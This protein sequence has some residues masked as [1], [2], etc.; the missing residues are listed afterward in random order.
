[1]SFNARL[2]ATVA[3]RGLLCVGLDPIYSELP[4]RFQGD[5]VEG[6]LVAANMALIEATAPY[7][8]AFK[9]QM[10][11]Y[12]AEGPAGF[13]AL[14]ATCRYLKARY[15]DHL[16][17]LDA[18]YGDVSHVMARS[19][20]EAFTLCNADAVTAFAHPGRLALAPLLADPERGCFVVCR[21]SN[22]GAPEMQDI[23]TAGGD[24]YYLALARQVAASWNA[25]DNCG[26]VAGATYPAEMAAIRAEAPDL[27]LLVPG[28]GAQGGD[29][30]AAVQAGMDGAG[31]GMLISA[32]RSLAAADPGAMAAGL[33]AQIRAALGAP[34]PAPHPGDPQV[35]ALVVEL[36]DKGYIQWKTVQLKSGRMSPYYLNLRGVSADPP[37]FGRLCRAFA[38]RA[39]ALGWT[40][41]VLLGIAHAGIP[42][43]VGTGG[44]LGRPAG[45]VRTDAKGYGTKQMVEGAKGG[46]R[47]LLLD[48]V[49][50]DGASKLEVLPA[51]TDAGL[52]VAGIL[53]FIDRGQGGIESVRAAGL[54]AEAVTTMPAAL[55]AL[56]AADRLTADQVAAADAFMRDARS[57]L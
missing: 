34:P 15:P 23:T 47:V 33:Q 38:A 31:G 53:V 39:G 4:E 17:I 46:Q 35:A 42:L 22:P 27:P 29:L 16:L 9:L 32:S 30:A 11:V 52:S 25:N 44:V 45:Y 43:A 14:I 37:L 2:A 5:D 40:Y 49:I 55:Q 8:A 51:L 56:Q 3:A 6:A 54:A 24:P 12:T 28:V 36:F 19:A 18:K 57:A 21:M 7:A 26:L 13:G 50:S 41:D 20:H 1:M 10:K 48:D